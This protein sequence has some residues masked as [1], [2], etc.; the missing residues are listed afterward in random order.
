MLSFRLF[1]YPVRIEWM[2]WLLCALIGMP[3]L[4]QQEPEAL[5]RFLVL[6]AV[7]L[8]SILW[9]EL[10]HAWAR[11]RCGEPYSEITLH[12]F[13]GL[14]G[15]PGHFTRHE[16]MFIAA[17][18][19]AASLLLGGAAFLPGYFGLGADP[20]FR[21]FLVLMITVNVVW[22]L[23]N[24]LPVLPLDGGRIFEALVANRRPG[25]APRVGFVVALVVAFVGLATG[26]IFLAVIF[27]FL[28]YG[29]YQRMRGF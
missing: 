7:I 25:L 13:G 9:H 20:S 14:C 6:V 21:F 15:G 24:L 16:T 1:G 8:G 5:L 23:L 18:G 10:G 11:R 26:R 22:A 29:N 12:G 27:G 28:A 3:L 17:A 19:P 4:Q 2:F